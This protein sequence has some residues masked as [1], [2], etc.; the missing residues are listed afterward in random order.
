[1]QNKLINR[2]DLDFVLYELLDVE[3]L[4]TRPRFAEHGRETFDAAIDTALKIA[5]EHF[6]PHNRKA[7]ENEPTFDG[8]RV[9]MIPEVK[10][11]LKVFCEAGLMAA[12]KNYDAGGVQLP[13]TVAQACLA[14]FNAANVSTAAYPFLTIA[15]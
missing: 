11:A 2:R 5:A 9:H 1:M 10:A 14:L 8:S 3:Q 13:I 12:S 4:T 6:A 15:N 7:D